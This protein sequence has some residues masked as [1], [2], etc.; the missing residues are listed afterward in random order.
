MSTLITLEK[1]GKRF[2]VY[3]PDRPRTFQETAL[4][5]VRKLKAQEVFWALREVSFTVSAGSMVGVIGQNGAGKS[6]LLRIIG[7]VVKPDE[8]TITTRGKIGA[9]IDLGAG[10][11]PDL[12][13][14]ENVFI[15]GIISGFTKQEVS[16]K[17]SSIVEFAELDEFIDNP[18]RTYSTGMQMRLAFSIAAHIQPE[19]LLIDEVLAVGDLSFQEKCLDRIASF[20]VQGCGIVLV[21]HNTDLVSKICDQAIWL[22]AGQIFAHGPADIVTQQYVN[23][24]QTET[25]RLTP[26]EGTYRLPDGEV[27]RLNENRFGSQEVQITNVRLLTD[28]NQP[29]HEIDSGDG[30]TVEITYQADHPVNS[31]IF[32]VTITKEDGLVWFDTSTDTSGM[33]IAQI[34]KTGNISLTL[35]RLDLLGGRYFI[36]VG[37]YHMDWTHAYDYHWQVYPLSVRSSPGEKGIIRPPYQWLISS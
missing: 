33:K 7:G 15:N 29:A 16:Q 32:G 28:D 9:L 23:E 11:H 17:F 4:H 37:V 5:G 34:H 26:K 36:N 19:I 27:L 20:K 8:G 2:R 10:F 18:L 31:P 21:S 25:R 35:Q 6:T 14:R 3:H 13:G 1:I 30:L 12:T 22:R 24:M